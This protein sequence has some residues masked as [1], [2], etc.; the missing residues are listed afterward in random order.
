MNIL[1]LDCQPILFSKNLKIYMLNNMI[2]FHVC[3]LSSS[4]IRIN[5]YLKVSIMKYRHKR[6]HLDYV[7]KYLDVKI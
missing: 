1:N 5:V 2:F 4:N 7:I 6:I 3:M